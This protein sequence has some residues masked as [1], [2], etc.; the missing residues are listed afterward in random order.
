MIEHHFG[1]KISPHHNIAS[2]CQTS[3]LDMIDVG[4]RPPIGSMRKLLIY[5]Q[6]ERKEHAVINRFWLTS[7]RLSL[8]TAR[9]GSYKVHRVFYMQLSYHSSLMNFWINSQLRCK[10]FLSENFISLCDLVLKA[11]SIFWTVIV[12]THLKC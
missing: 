8:Q 2:A 6:D 3:T 7:Q 5:F 12:L 4:N 9:Q 1:C 11:S 10:F